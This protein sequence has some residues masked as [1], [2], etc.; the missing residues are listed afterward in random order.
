M[1]MTDFAKAT[2]VALLARQSALKDQVA[3]KLKNSTQEQM[4]VVMVNAGIVTKG[5][6][7]AAPY[8]MKERAG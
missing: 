8:R 2:H 7:L 5:G 1:P 4:R 3:A 6:R